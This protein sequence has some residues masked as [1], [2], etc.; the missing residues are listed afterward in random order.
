MTGTLYSDNCALLQ[1][2][3]VYSG[4]GRLIEVLQ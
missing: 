1:E 3:G 4:P 2:P